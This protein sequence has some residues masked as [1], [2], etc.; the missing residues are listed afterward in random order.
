MI[1][2]A[3]S[4]QPATGSALTG[5]TSTTTS[6]MCSDDGQVMPT[7]LTPWL[8]SAAFRDL[9]RRQIRLSPY[10]GERQ[11]HRPCRARHRWHQRSRTR[12][13][14]RRTEQPAP[15]SSSARATSP[16]SPCRT[17]STSSRRPARS[18]GGRRRRRRGGLAHSAASTSSS[19]TPAA[20]PRR[21]RRRC[22]RGSS[23]RSSRSTCSRRST[24]RSA[25][26]R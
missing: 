12:R 15:T 6:A 3:S 16:R 5:G 26:T 13:W 17:V 14:Q 7:T 11:P 1:V 4:N 2:S 22:R 21:T 19:T 8:R 24:S 23:R 10:T 9:M 18:G 25:P 20:R